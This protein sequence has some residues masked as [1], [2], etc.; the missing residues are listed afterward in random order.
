MGI[1]IGSG[2]VFGRGLI[3]LAGERWGSRIAVSSVVGGGCLPRGPTSI[4]GEGV[5]GVV[6]DVLAAAVCDV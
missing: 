6:C 2:G 5:L 3:P 4:H 1:V